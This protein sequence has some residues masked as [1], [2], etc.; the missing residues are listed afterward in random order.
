MTKTKIFSIICAGFFTFLPAGHAL[1]A[2]TTTPTIRQRLTAA[3][4]DNSR[5]TTPAKADTKKAEEKVIPPAEAQTAWT[6]A[7]SNSKLL[8]YYD[9]NSLKYD[10]NTGIITAWTKWVYKSAGTPT[11][12]KTVLLLSRYDVRVKVFADLYYINYAGNGTI[13]KEGP[14]SDQSWSP[15]SINT[16]GEDMQT[17]LNN[18]LI[19]H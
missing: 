16:L 6:P 5:S 19:S 7:G 14:A 10:K 9:A 8:T 18:Y 1:M 11:S 17:A 15:I 12:L 13:L 4:K 2:P 3:S